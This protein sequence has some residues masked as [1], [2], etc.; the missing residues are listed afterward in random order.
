MKSVLKRILTA[1]LTKEATWL[2]KK[3]NPKIIVV[4]GSVGKTS[5]KDAIYAVLVKAFKI[6][7]SEKSFNSDIGIPLTILGCQNAWS[8]P[9]GW[10][11]NLWQ[12]LR[13]LLVKSDYP[14]WLVLEVGA[15]R[16]GDIERVSHW[17]KP[18]VTVLTKFAKTPVH[19]EF[20]KNRHEVIREK[21]FMVEALKR[22]GV[23][24]LNSD[25]ED[26]FGFKQKTTSK[27]LTYGLLPEAEVKASYIE[28][29]YENEKLKGLQF[30][31][32]Y[33]G[34]CVP[35]IIKDVVGNQAVYAALGAV[36]V[37]LSLD[38][39]LIQIA[40][41]LSDYLSPRGRMKLISGLK[42][43][44]LI[45]DTYNS[46]PVALHS[47]LETLAKVKTSGRRFAILGDMLE[48]GKHS[49]TEHKEVGVVA[50]R[51]CDY[52]ITVG[53]RSRNLAEA[54]LENGLSEKNVLQF[55]SAIEAGKYV[56]NMIQENDVILVKGSQSMRMEKVVAEI[57]AEPEKAIDLLVR[58][59]EEWQ[60]K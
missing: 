13:L 30:K 4:T 38:L 48:L 50:A 20:F 46:S 16:P 15:D 57:M 52:L 27:V 11:Q 55:E 40:E 24:V 53:L 29:Y 44:I 22:D 36:T 32:D 41:G 25:D 35:I 47:A 2:L 33:G 54:A 19:I 18:D 17:L 14:E 5:T 58:Q 21:G 28:D 43:T 9:L 59:E 3:Y 26:A 10:L 7:K 56:Q 60:K 1:I 23:L 45:D 12:G 51:C 31:V 42:Q 49:V 34:S 37:G 6:R 8:N 39:N